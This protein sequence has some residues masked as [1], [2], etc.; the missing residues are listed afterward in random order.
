MVTSQFNKIPPAINHDQKGIFSVLPPARE[1]LAFNIGK[2]KESKALPFLWVLKSLIKMSLLSKE[3]VVSSHIFIILLNKG[4]YP[5]H[6]LANTFSPCRNVDIFLQMAWQKGKRERWLV[7]EDRHVWSLSHTSQRHWPACPS[8][9]ASGLA[10]SRRFQCC[11][12]CW[13]GQTGDRKEVT[14]A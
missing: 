6:K 8:H 14:S 4:I 5:A 3:R 12:H 13:E 2:C 11:R 7:T 10:G 1:C 9:P